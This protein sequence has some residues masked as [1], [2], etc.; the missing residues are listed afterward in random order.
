MKA[1]SIAC[2]ETGMKEAD[3]LDTLAAAQAE[4]GDFAAAVKTAGQAIAPHAQASDNSLTAE[5]Q[6]RLACIGSG[7]RTGKRR[8]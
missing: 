1:A 4:A 7:H 8:R 2:E 5:Y 6:S 3:Y